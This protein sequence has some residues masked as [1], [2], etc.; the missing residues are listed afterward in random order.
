[1]PVK[2]SKREQNKGLTQNQKLYFLNGWCLSV[3][4]S[5]GSPDFPF[6]SE[7]EYRTLYFKYRS[8]ILATV[9]IS[10]KDRAPFE[11]MDWDRLRPAAW[12]EFEGP[13]KQ[14]FWHNPQAELGCLERYGLVNSR[15]REITAEIRQEK[16]NLEARRKCFR[17]EE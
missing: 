8:E 2:R 17:L 3:L 15:D 7:K 5:E 9:N 6:R 14:L 13:E 4:P 1:M 11:D 16:E 12:W 10:L